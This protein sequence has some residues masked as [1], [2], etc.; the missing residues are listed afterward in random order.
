MSKNILPKA[1][2]NANKILITGAFATGKS[3]LCEMLEK[4]FRLL[5][6]SSSLLSGVPRNSPFALNKKQTHLASSWLVGEQIRLEVFHSTKAKN[7]LIC[8]RG[9]PDIISHTIILK[10][11][12][13]D[14]KL[15]KILLKIAKEWSKTYDL[16]FWAKLN[17]KFAIP[18]DGIRIPKKKYQIELEDSIKKTFRLLDIDYIEMPSDTVERKKFVIE[19]VKKIICPERK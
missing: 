17:L 10:T 4:E 6:L 12:K 2:S 14:E 7:I 9:I 15:F 8:D 13:R 18:K 19:K 11:D 16:I 5:G 3:T 1:I